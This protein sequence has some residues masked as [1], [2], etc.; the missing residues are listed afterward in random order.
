M[1]AKLELIL[2]FSVS[3]PE[4]EKFAIYEGVD[5]GYTIRIYPPMKS[6]Q[7]LQQGDL[8]EI[9]VNGRSSF[10]AN[11]LRIYFQ[12]DNF[13]RR[14]SVDCDPPFT[15]IS[16]TINLFLARLRFV[17][18]NSRMKPINFPMVSWHLQ[19]L[20]DDGS[21]LEKNEE[22][23]RGRFGKSFKFSLAPLTKE[24]WDEVF[25]L[26][27]DYSLPKWESLILDAK[28]ALPEIGVSIV[29]A[30][31]ALEVFISHVLGEL[32]KDKA[33]PNDLWEW[34][35]N[36]QWWLQ[37]P[38]TDEQF[39]VLLKVLLGISLKENLDLWESFKNLKVARN[40][41]IHEGIAKIGGDV[42]SQDKALALLKKAENIIKFIKEKLPERLQ[43]RDYKFSTKIEAKHKLL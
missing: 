37:N 26:P 36:R 19:Y 4:K 24:M 32:S 14:K 38:S 34:L 2:P 15:F 41:F 18:H 8:T 39:D 23:V 13:D 28:E 12:K 9:K 21:E 5:S 40:S 7:L 6:T 27:A 16:Q 43:W 33:I 1:L 29:L 10:Q 42:L 30:L 35:N 25:R 20:N 17:T 31:T 11:G 3:I 22:L